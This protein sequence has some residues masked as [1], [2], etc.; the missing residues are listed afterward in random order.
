MVL[1]SEVIAER[2]MGLH[3]YKSLKIAERL[4]RQLRKKKVFEILCRRLLKKKRHNV[5][6]MMLQMSIPFCSEPQTIKR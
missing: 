2:H 4:I 3:I 5:Y 6:L 1:F